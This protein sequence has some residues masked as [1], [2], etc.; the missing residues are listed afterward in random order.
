MDRT[1]EPLI[2][3]DTSWLVDPRARAVCDAIAQGGHAV[4]FVGGCVRNALLGLPDSDVDLSTDARPEEALA[5]LERL[6][7]W[8]PYDLHEKRSR[9]NRFLFFMPY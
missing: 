6:R 4:F 8:R 2:P 9:F 3:S 7:A 1:D 5:L